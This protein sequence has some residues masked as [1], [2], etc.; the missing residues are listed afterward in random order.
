MLLPK[1][2]CVSLQ[3]FCGFGSLR[4][5]LAKGGEEVDHR[6]LL[7]SVLCHLEEERE[8]QLQER[9]SSMKSCCFRVGG[10]TFWMLI[11]HFKGLEY[12]AHLFTRTTSQ[13]TLMWVHGWGEL[14]D[15]NCTG[16][17]LLCKSSSSF[18]RQRIDR[19]YIIENLP[20]SNRFCGLIQDQPSADHLFAVRMPSMLVSTCSTVACAL[21]CVPY[22][23]PCT[24]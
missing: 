10:A 19:N 6:Q 15:I 12:L 18:A 5:F 23:H 9:K 24:N 3:R 22:S 20:R 13:V 11:R 21:E 4:P 17:F 2:H 7:E 1:N 14:I 8:K 16:P